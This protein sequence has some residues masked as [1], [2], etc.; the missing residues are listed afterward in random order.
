MNEVAT[1]FWNNENRFWVITEPSTSNSY[2]AFLDI[3]L[4]CEC[5]ELSIENHISFEVSSEDMINHLTSNTEIT[6]WNLETNGRT[7]MTKRVD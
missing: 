1:S 2:I 4:C 6:I 3:E 5:A 7:T